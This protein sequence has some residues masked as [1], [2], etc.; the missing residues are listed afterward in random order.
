M[1]T[2]GEMIV[3]PQELED[4]HETPIRESIFA[5]AADEEDAVV[6][7][8][9]WIQSELNRAMA[10]RL[11]IETVWEE[12]LRMYEGVSATAIKNT[13]IENASNIEVT[14]GA[15]ACEGIY[16]QIINLIF[17]VDPIVTVRETGATGHWKE[18]V[19]DLQRFVDVLAKSKLGLRE[20]AE[21]AVLDDVK[22]GTGV[23][24]TRWQERTKKTQVET[25]TERGPVMRAVPVEDF[26]VPG[27]AYSDLQT[28]RWV[29]FRQYLTWNELNQRS[30]DLGWNIDEV[31]P[32][33]GLDRTRRTRERLGRHDSLGHHTGGEDTDS[34]TLYQIFTLW[35]LYD[36]DGDGILEDLLVTYDF[37]SRGVIAWGFNPYDRRPFNVMRYQLREHLFYGLGVIE[38]MRPYQG[39]ATNLYNN[40]IDNSQLANTRFWVGKHGA[41]PNNQ[42]RIWPN[43]YLPLPNP[44]ED[45]IPHVMADTY[46]SAPLALQTT[47]S[48]GAKRV[49][50]DDLGNPQTRGGVLGNRTPGITALSMLQRSNER[51]GPA[52]DAARRT[53]SGA[54]REALFRYQERLLLGDAAVRQELVQMFGEDSAQR[55]IEIMTDPQFDNGVTV[56]LTASSAQVNRESDRQNWIL[57]FQQIF[58]FGERTALGNRTPG[59]T[60][61]SMLQRSNERFGPAFDAAR[62]TVSGAVRE[63]L[64]RYQERLLLG[65]AAVRQELVQMFGEDSA[66]RLIEI[67]TDPQFDNGVTVELTASSAQ[68]NRE[69]DRQNWI[70][71]FQQIFTF[72]ERIMQLVGVIESPETGPLMKDTAQQ[73]V[74][75]G[76][77]IMSRTMRTFDQVRDPTSFLIELNQELLEGDQSVDENQL[78]ALGDALAQQ[79]G[80]GQN[81]VGSDVGALGL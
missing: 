7:L 36:F 73:L 74:N 24:Y 51:F 17:Q 10:A 72:G 61:L 12:N 16:A 69:S 37:G 56:E 71:L 48:L 66:Q 49:G 57:L 27:G 40:W 78:A 62:R 35:C 33:G 32:S 55:L 59:I 28:E 43:R 58:T 64:F 19:K 29:G 68:V 70:L 14:L 63:A 13:P 34:G 39:G 15:T 11:N 60:A 47:M 81:G 31:I 65:D 67:M 21:N 9:A 75:I 6:D 25:V 23:I 18:H 4:S 3:H 46:P 80:G 45:L 77:E 76:N 52:F 54:V 44:R 26:F 1:A 53:V 8:A 42:L 22:L 79:F 50:V 20:A 38:M 41:I 2:A 5:S 30:K